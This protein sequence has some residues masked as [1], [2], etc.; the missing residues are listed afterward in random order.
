MTNAFIITTSVVSLAAV[1][2]L[3]LGPFASLRRDNFRSDIRRIRDDLFDYM[4]EN[5]L[6]FE[7]K[8]YR[9]TR[10]LLNGML[11]A[12]TWLA[13]AKLLV[14]LFFYKWYEVEGEPTFTSYDNCSAELKSK[15]LGAAANA[16]T[17][18]IIFLFAEGTFGV[19]LKCTLFVFWQSRRIE[20][21]ARRL[22]LD[23]YSLG[24]PAQE[25]TFSQRSALRC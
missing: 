24:A 13:P 20:V 16:I 2:A 5:G 19:L 17:R 6:D 14:A 15:L 1:V 10:Q 22:A 23:L 7:N 25:L 21:A 11:R 3:W 8:A 4:W 12:S 18:M 9:D